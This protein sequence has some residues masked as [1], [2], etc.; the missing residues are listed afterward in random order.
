MMLSPINAPEEILRKFP[1]TFIHVGTVD[2]L[3]GH[4]VEFYE[5]L[6]AVSQNTVVLREYKVFL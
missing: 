2:P 5:K 6:K 4:S 3:H 1:P